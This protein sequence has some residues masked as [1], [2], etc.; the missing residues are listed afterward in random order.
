M[1]ARLALALLVLVGHAGAAA[2]VPFDTLPADSVAADTVDQT[3][4]YLREQEQNAVRLPVLP[5]IGID[6]PRPP[7]SRIVF[8]RDSIDWTTAQTVADLLQRVPGVYLWR[9]GWIGRP[10]YPNYQGRGPHTAEYYLDGAPYAPLGLDSLG[11][12]PSLFPMS[13]L[14]RI[15]V[16]RWPGLLRVHLFTRRHDRLAARSRIGI[17]AGDRDVARYA[18]ALERRFRS[19]AGFAV[20][21]EYLNAPT[22]SGVR[23][24]ASISHL[25]LQGGYVPSERFGVQYQIVR[26]KPNRRAFEGGAAAADTLGE[27]LKGNRSDAQLRLFLRRRGDDLGPRLDV[28]YVRSGWEGGEVHQQNNQFGGVFSLRTPTARLGA[29]AFIRSRWTT[30]D[31]RVEG[32]WAPVAPLG[33]SAEVGYQRHDLGRE[34]RWV[35]ARAGVVLPLGLTATGTLRHG[36]IVFAPALTADPAQDVTDLSVV[37]GWQHRLVGVELGYHHTDAFRPQAYQPFRVVDSLAPVGAADWVTASLRLAPLSWLTLE[38]WYSDPRG[39]AIEG[40]PPTHFLGSATIRSRFLRTFPSGAFDLKLQGIV[41]AWGTGVIGRDAA[42]DPIK[43]RGAT[44]Y[45]GVLELRLQSFIIYWD[46]YNLRSSRH[47]YV[48]G[49]GIPPGGS[50]FGVRWEFV[51]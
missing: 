22:A 11:V 49:F 20:A 48:P 45:R 10:E 19:G 29:S 34:S 32:G 40:I 2:Q 37:A 47:A 13:L 50:T 43:L 44:F 1:S 39:P 5:R 7:S 46:R 9:G 23:S 15:E 38:G 33:A 35:G 42:G 21:G 51:N 31:A 6:G 26:S 25:L 18:G 36:S 12:D 30:F 14:E 8:D 4:R 41:E 17:A 28:L 3:A 24:D 16:E 27:P